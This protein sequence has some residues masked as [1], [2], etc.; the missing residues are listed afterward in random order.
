MTENKPSL[1]PRII[2]FSL[3]ILCF[4]F[5]VCKPSVTRKQAELCIN[6]F[7]VLIYYHYYYYYLYRCGSIQP[8]DK[9]LAINDIRM[10]PCCA[11]E[12]ANLLET[13]DDIIVLKLRRDDPYGGNE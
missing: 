7:L 12:A 3:L 1:I 9:L 4:C 13:V 5:T 2:I 6:A 11:D 8:S 10:E